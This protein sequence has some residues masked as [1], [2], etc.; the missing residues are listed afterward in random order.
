MQIYSK[1]AEQSGYLSFL[2]N[3]KL[4]KHNI[5]WMNVRHLLQAES[6]KR[7]CLNMTKNVFGKKNIYTYYFVGFSDHLILLKS[8]M[9]H[10]F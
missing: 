5:C 1:A 3:N 2:I 8:E 7:F 9:Y 4:L 10:V 6:C